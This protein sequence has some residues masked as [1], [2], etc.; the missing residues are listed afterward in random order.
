MKYRAMLIV[1]IEA[2]SNDF[3]QAAR[4]AFKKIADKLN[5]RATVE[6]SIMQKDGSGQDIAAEA[7]IDSC[8]TAKTKVNFIR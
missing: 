8:H 6:I 4:K 3:E 5:S 2:E 1:E 7:V